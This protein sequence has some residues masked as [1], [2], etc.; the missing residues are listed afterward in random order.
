MCFRGISV[1]TGFG[2]AVAIGDWTRFTGSTIGSYLGLT[3]SEHSSA[4]SRPQGP[5]TK[6]GNTYARRLLIDAAWSHARPYSRPGVRLLRQFEKV[7]TPTRTRAIEENQRLCRVWANF[8]AR[9]K[10]RVKAASAVA[11]ELAGWC[12]VRGRATAAISG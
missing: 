10:R 7:D 1:V 3:P 4:Q 6:A 8:D 12:L 11:R 5:I 9:G 2:L